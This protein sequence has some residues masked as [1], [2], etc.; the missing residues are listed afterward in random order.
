M[1]YLATQAC[2]KNKTADNLDE[3]QLTIY[4]CRLAP[5]NVDAP[6]SISASHSVILRG[7]HFCMCAAYLLLLH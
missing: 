1:I 7:L 4:A 3:G 6:W 2:S 5:V